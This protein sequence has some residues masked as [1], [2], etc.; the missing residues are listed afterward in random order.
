MERK[1]DKSMD[2]LASWKP[3]F[4]DFVEMAR[5]SALRAERYAFVEQRAQPES[6]GFSILSRQQA[7]RE[8]WGYVFAMADCELPAPIFKAQRC[9]S[10][11]RS[12][13]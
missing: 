4:D 11:Q 8:A 10:L 5:H 12:L 9:W 3:D 13:S 1:R 7:E 6:D 2:S